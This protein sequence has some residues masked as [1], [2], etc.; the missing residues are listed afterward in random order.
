MGAYAEL[1]RGEACSRLVIARGTEAAEV[2]LRWGDVATVV[3]ESGLLEGLAERDVGAHALAA[4]FFI[5]IADDFL[6]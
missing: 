3:E 1:R 6:Q 5:V 4:G 2:I